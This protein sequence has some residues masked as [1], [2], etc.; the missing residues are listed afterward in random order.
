M[1]IATSAL[2]G[3]ARERSTTLAA[4][5]GRKSLQDVARNNAQHRYRN[6]SLPDIDWGDS[7]KSPSKETSGKNTDRSGMSPNIN[8]SS[9]PQGVNVY[10]HNS[11]LQPRH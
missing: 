8:Y 2:A 7:I 6:S 10:F 1:R 9:T 5:S 3:M 4:G 11:A